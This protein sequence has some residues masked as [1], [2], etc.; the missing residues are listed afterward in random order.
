MTNQ[1]TLAVAGWVRVPGAL[2][3]WI[4]TVLAEA[5]G[6]ALVT[7]TPG[8][9]VCSR[10]STRECPD[11]PSGTPTVAEPVLARDDRWV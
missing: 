4:V 3:K 11:N 7:K 10:S 2:F 8:V 1:A 6:T 9:A 5:R